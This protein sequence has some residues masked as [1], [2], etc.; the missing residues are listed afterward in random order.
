MTINE[1]SRAEKLQYDINR[2]TPK[3]FAL[4]SGKTNKYEQLTGEDQTTNQSGQTNYSYSPL[5]RVFYRQIK[6]IKDQGET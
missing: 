6:T 4:W 3:I 5:R 2:E 1:K